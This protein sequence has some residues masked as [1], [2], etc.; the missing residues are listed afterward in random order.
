MKYLIIVFALSLFTSCNTAIKRENI[1][2]IWR[3]DKMINPHEEEEYKQRKKMVDTMTFSAPWDREYWGTDDPVKIRK[4][5]L[6][7]FENEKLFIREKLQ[8]STKQYLEDGRLILNVSGKAIDTIKWEITSDN[9]L[10]EIGEA[11]LDTLNIDKLTSKKLVISK[12]LF[13]K[14]AE[15]HYNKDN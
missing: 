6:E 12:K 2:G 13:D 9:K 10:V 3:G 5:I 8:N 15:I 1:I 14:K 7:E 4:K 11:Y